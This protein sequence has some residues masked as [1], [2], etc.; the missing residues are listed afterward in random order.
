MA[1]D[2]SIYGAVGR[3]VK[4]VAEY[5]AEAQAAKANKLQML[6]AQGQ[7]G[8]FQQGL[9]DDNALRRIYAENAGDPVRVGN[10][11]AAGGLYKQKQAFDKAQLDARKEQVGLDKTLIETKGLQQKQQYDATDR[12]L[13]SLSGVNTPEDAQAWVQSGLSAGVFTPE[14][15]QAGMQRFTQSLQQPGGLQAWKQQA[16]MGGATALQQLEE[17]NKKRTF[18]ATNANNIMTEDGQGGYTVN[19]PLVDA[20]KRVAKAGASNIDV[21]VNAKLGEGVAAQV[22][23]MMRDSFEQAQGAQ[24]SIQTA[25]QLI[26]A[27]DSGKT[28]TGPGASLRL[29]GAQ[30]AETLGIGGKDTAEKIANTRA[31]IQGLAQTTLTA[32]KQLAGQGQV[33]DNE[34]RLLERAA[35]GNLDDMTSSEIRQIAEVN[36]RLAQRQISIHK[37]RASKLKADPTTD[38]L[39][40]FYDLP[41]EPAA[42]APAQ[43]AP[44]APGVWKVIR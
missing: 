12:H 2:A 30:V 21:K 43:A 31:A 20:K 44:A 16:L 27:I 32:R 15:A 41:D 14:Q 37:Q 3:G 38:G 13:Q 36:K 5:D 42:A 9:A 18:G 33:S 4:S 1:L 40:T 29:K 23:P 22:G 8:Q 25:D 10:A 6:M 19:Q 11:L 7:Y 34:G 24:S 28:I 17:A 26:K 39:A 35:S